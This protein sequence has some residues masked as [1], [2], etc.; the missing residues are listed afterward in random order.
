MAKRPFEIP[1][2]VLTAV[3]AEIAAVEAACK[4]RKTIKEGFKETEPYDRSAPTKHKDLSG[5]MEAERA[6]VCGKHCN[7]GYN[8]AG[9]SFCGAAANNGKGWASADAAVGKAGARAAHGNWAAAASARCLS[10]GAHAEAKGLHAAA[11]CEVT[12][13]KADAKLETGVRFLDKN[14]QA[15]AS[16]PTAGAKG[17]ASLE[18]LTLSASAGAHAG[19]VKA[20]PWAL[21][22]GVEIGGGVEGGV[23]VL[24]LGPVS[25]PCCIQ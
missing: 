21:R 20:G 22:A 23:P 9:A 3:N 14:L 2:E 6:E 13:A 4:W 19:E 17:E 1:Q 12:V 16:A 18:T 7:D 24:H 5:D 15:S 11:G 10:A 25:T 8:R